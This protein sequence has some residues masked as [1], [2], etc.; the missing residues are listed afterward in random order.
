MEKFEE[1]FRRADLD[2]DGRISGAEAV[3]FFQAS[4][5]PKPTLAQFRVLSYLNFLD[6][7][8][9][10]H[11]QVNTYSNPR[12]IWQHADQN[13]TG[14]LGR[15]E[16]YN[17]LKLVTVAQSK[18]ELTPDIV[19][20]ALYGP[21]SSKIPAPQINLAALPPA[22]P[23]A[24][25][26]RPTTQQPGIVNSM[27][28]RPPTQQPGVVNSMQ[29]HTFGIRSQ[30]PP[31]SMAPPS[32]APPSAQYFAPQGNQ[33][34]RP[35]PQ[36]GPLPSQG[37]SGPS[38][39]AG[40]GLAGPGLSNSNVSGDWLGGIGVGATVPKPQEP[41]SSSSFTAPRPSVGG[42]AITSAAM[43]GGDLFSASQ[44]ISKPSSSSMPTQ[45]ASIPPVSSAIAPVT[46]EPQAPVK[47]DPLA[48]CPFGFVSAPALSLQAPHLLA[49]R[50]K[51]LDFGAESLL[52]GL[53]KNYLSLTFG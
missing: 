25:G 5:L 11:G 23:N 15:Q 3:A 48:L 26:P 28:P 49:R 10:A 1:Y 21:A 51:R 32:V 27:A 34:M 42:N 8:T 12:N 30:G 40:G 18:R 14:F 37:V 2:K 16:F 20:A 41:L 17:A 13:R 22:Q 29:T 35:P 44:S 43:F 47:I 33:S 52:L 31:N 38:F 19:K 53:L 36:S 39:P 46:S 7:L 9:S 50:V 4:N 45:T 24:I 6:V